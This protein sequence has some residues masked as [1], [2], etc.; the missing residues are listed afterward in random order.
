MADIV[1]YPN[2]ILRKKV[3][4]VGLVDKKTASQ[5]KLLQNTLEKADF[6][7]GLAATQL[8]IEKRFFGIKFAKKVRVFINPKITKCFGKMVFPAILDENEK[9]EEFLEGCL[10][11]PNLFGTVKRYLKIEVKWKEGKTILE[12]FEAIIFQH[13]LDHLNGILFID[14]VKKD[15]GKL[16]QYIKGK[17]VEVLL[18]DLIQE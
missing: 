16:Y 13:E 2:E 10:S 7:V 11:F 18:S 14:H 17:K 1:K 4:E 5:V 12:G 15:Y 3:A 8:G 6:A 9:S